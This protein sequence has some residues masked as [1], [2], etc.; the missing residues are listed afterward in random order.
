[1]VIEQAKGMLAEYLTMTMDDAFT[2]L[3]NFA[4]DNN[5]KLSELAGDIADRW[6]PSAALAPRPGREP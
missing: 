4:R 1:V 5:R 3:R 2:L 6:V